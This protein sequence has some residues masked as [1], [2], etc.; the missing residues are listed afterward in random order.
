M[1]KM[2]AHTCCFRGWAVG[3]FDRLKRR[4]QVKGCLVQ[5]PAITGC[6]CPLSGP[7]RGEFEG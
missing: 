5:L 3:T 6:V 1:D 4:T 2:L 7:L